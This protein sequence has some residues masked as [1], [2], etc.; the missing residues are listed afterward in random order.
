MNK[1]LMIILGMIF[2]LC[3]CV[4]GCQNYGPDPIEESIKET[5]EKR[6]EITENKQTEPIENTTD[7]PKESSEH[8]TEEK[9]HETTD[10]A[11]YCGVGYES[12]EELL[13]KQWEA[14]KDQKPNGDSWLNSTDGQISLIIPVL[15][16]DD[17]ML[18][19]V[20]DGGECIV[21]DY[22][23]V[24]EDDPT[25]FSVVLWFS[26]SSYEI[27]LDKGFNPEND[28]MYYGNGVVFGV[29]GYCFECIFPMP[30]TDNEGRRV[31]IE[32][33]DALLDFEMV[34]YTFTDET[35]AVQ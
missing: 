27:F 28:A 23:A 6:S 11:Q 17:Y 16:N 18:A 9:N 8:Q 32:E 25:Y 1:K 7:D 2:A 30:I 21:F 13:Q 24:D 10:G 34:T 5:S 15:K 14:Q 29:N 26:P 20:D 31:T 35:D 22:E 4:A 19:R 33:A 3:L 12:L